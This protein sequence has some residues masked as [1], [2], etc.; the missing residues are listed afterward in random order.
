MTPYKAAIT[1]AKE[2][3]F[4]V[5]AMT[6]TLA[7]VYVLSF[8]IWSGWLFWRGQTLAKGAAELVG[9]HP[10]IEEVRVLQARWQV[11]EP[12]TNVDSYPTELFHRVASLLPDE[13]IQLKE[14]FLE[15][16]KL[17]VSGK[18]S[19]IGHAKKFQADL[20]GGAGLHQYTWNFPQ[21]TILEDNQASFRAEGTLGT[22]G[23]GR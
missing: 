23:E 4:A 20:T 7:A 2:I 5:L 14:F 3:S 8:A 10:E 17:V 18:A 1:G 21:P 22:G 12:A 13:G 15:T 9:L 6:I 11:L 16:D 19:T